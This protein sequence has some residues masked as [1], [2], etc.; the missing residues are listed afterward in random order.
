MFHLTKVRDKMLRKTKRNL[1]DISLWC[2]MLSMFFLPLGYDFIF[3]W[4][5]NI[6]GSYWGAVLVFYGISATFLVTHLL[7][8]RYINKNS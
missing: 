5:M 8:K 2:L 4:V 7:L 6:T 3:K 1:S